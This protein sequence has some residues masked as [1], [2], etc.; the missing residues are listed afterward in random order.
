MKD[1]VEVLMAILGTIAFIALIVFVMPFVHFWVA[2]F[3]G[4]ITMKIMN[5]DTML[6]LTKF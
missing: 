6:V 3:G 1:F 2:Y 5:L 4:W